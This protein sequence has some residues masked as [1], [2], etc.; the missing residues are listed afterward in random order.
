[1][2]PKFWEKKG[3]KQTSQTHFEQR[4]LFNLISE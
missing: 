3:S 2:K 4:K 1:M